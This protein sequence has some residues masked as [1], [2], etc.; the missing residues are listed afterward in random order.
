MGRAESHLLVQSVERAFFP[1]D[2][3]SHA[4]QVSMDHRACV[5]LWN[6]GVQTGGQFLDRLWLVASWP[7]IGDDFEVGHESSGRAA[8]RRAPRLADCQ[9]YRSDA[10]S[11]R[12]FGSII[13]RDVLF[14]FT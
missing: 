13:G 11:D 6:C 4:H 2:A 7:E 5:R 9:V 14:Y 8:R 1:A 3:A 12:D 10:I